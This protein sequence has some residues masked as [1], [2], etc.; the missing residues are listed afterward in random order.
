M[1]SPFSNSGE[2]LLK[3]SAGNISEKPYPVHWFKFISTMSCKTGIS[4]LSIPE[5][6]PVH[7]AYSPIA[8]MNHQWTINLHGVE[9]PQVAGIPGV[10]QDDTVQVTGIEDPPIV[11]TVEEGTE[12]EPV[13]DNQEHD[14]HRGCKQLYTHKYNP[15]KYRMAMKNVPKTS[16]PV[17]NQQVLW[18]KGLK[19]FGV[20]A[21]NA[22]KRNIRIFCKS[23][24]PSGLVLM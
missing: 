12:Y 23:K 6:T 13:D 24:N 2:H 21:T 1:F 15:D 16:E 3:E 5:P 9:I 8:S 17:P 7:V 22:I 14:L 11:E 4:G 20:D 18:K 19:M 10:E